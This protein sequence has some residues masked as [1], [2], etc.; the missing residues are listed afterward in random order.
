MKKKTIVILLI[1][2]IGIISAC[3]ISKEKNVSQYPNLLLGTNNG[4]DNF[5]LFDKGYDASLEPDGDGI[6]VTIHSHPDEG[7]LVLFYDDGHSKEIL[8]GPEG[9]EYTLVFEAK[10]NVKNAT[11]GIGHR[12]TDGQEIQIAFGSVTINKTN[13]WTQ[14]VLTSTLKGI[15]ETNQGIYFSLKHNPAN[16]EI[17][18]RNLKLI[19]GKV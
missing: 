4:T 13:K 1:V 14:Y 7:Y 6:K 5:K 16:T 17:S 18:I 10:S 19:K 2:A 12:Q 11:I 8:A 9:D 15:P 3:S